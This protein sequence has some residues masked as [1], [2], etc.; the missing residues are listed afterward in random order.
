M[1]TSPLNRLPPVDGFVQDD[2]VE[3]KVVGT[4]NFGAF[5]AVSPP[6]GGDDVTALLSV[7]QMKENQRFRVGDVVKARVKDVD[8]EK[9]QVF[10]S[11]RPHM[12]AAEPSETATVSPPTATKSRVTAAALAEAAAQF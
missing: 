12:T 9:K 5:V 7:S 3:G 10:L 6:S 8:K 11:M 2:W 4:V 1:G